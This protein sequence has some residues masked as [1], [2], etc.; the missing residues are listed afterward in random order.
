MAKVFIEEPQWN[1]SS[2]DFFFL[3]CFFFVIFCDFFHFKPKK[4][5]QQTKTISK[6]LL[7]TRKLY[8]R[9]RSLILLKNKEDWRK[10]VV[11][12]EWKKV[13]FWKEKKIGG[14]ADKGLWLKKKKHGG[15]DRKKKNKNR[16][17]LVF[18]F[19]A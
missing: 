6:L 13:G 19:Y 7:Q 11:F 1:N 9:I 15:G 14:V 12:W 2:R 5:L 10:F 18:L 16:D 4:N 17:G 3:F 8:M